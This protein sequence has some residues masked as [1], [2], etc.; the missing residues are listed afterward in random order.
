MNSS[1]ILRELIDETLS[2]SDSNHNS[3]IESNIGEEFEELRKS[4]LD[5]FS[6]SSSPVI[7]QDPN[8]DYLDDPN[9]DIEQED[10]FETN[11]ENQHNSEEDVGLNV[12]NHTNRDGDVNDN[13]CEIDKEGWREWTDNDVGFQKFRFVLNSGFKPPQG[14]TPQTELDFF[15]LYFTDELII[16]LVNETNR[17]A[18]EK[19][20]Q[21]TP[22]CKRSIWWSWTDVTHE[23]MKAFFGVLINMGLHP[24]PELDDYFSTDITN[25]QPFF[26]NIFSKTRF[27]QIFWNLHVSP[28]DRNGPVRGTLTRSGKVRKVVEYLD[29]QYRKYY[30]PEHKISVDESTVAFKGRV[31]F[32]VYNKDKPIKWGIKVF[33]MSEASTGY[34]CGLIPYLGKAT[35]DNLIRPDLL[36]TS[37]IVLHLVNKLQEDYGEVQ[38]F[39]V[40]TDRFYTSV[41]LASAL[42]DLKVHL[43]GT[44]M[45]NRKGLPIK[46]R[47]VKGKKKVT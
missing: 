30:V 31:H 25:Y 5:R 28:P 12:P 40:F 32:K 11:N 15:T 17:Y 23:E 14:Q 34:I 38:G 6:L 37:R 43:T 46:V 4:E 42:H 24:K 20:Q 19:I 10:L 13:E 39:H 1:D 9:Y 36:V 35:T 33:V 21:N 8:N 47:C 41:E 29:K 2:D 16:E 26:S 27:M 44:I 45:R 18:R 7:E 22:L 3:D